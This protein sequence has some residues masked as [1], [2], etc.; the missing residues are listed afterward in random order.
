MTRAETSTRFF[1]DAPETRTLHQG[2]DG[3]RPAAWQGLSAPGDFDRAQGAANPEAQGALVGRQRRAVGGGLR[4]AD[5]EGAVERA[6]LGEPAADLA[7]RPV[8]LLDPGRLHLAAAVADEGDSPHRAGGA[9][10]VVPRVVV[11]GHDQLHL[12][13]VGGGGALLGLERAAAGGG[14]PGGG[15][16]LPPR[17]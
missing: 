11:G 8:V 3:T 12:I 13:R 16:R 15:G 7:A 2:L 17:G 5:D 6:E 4:E 9:G 14:A 1:M 10:E